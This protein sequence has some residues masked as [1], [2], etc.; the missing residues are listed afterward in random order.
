MDG[1]RKSWLIKIVLFSLLVSMSC[2][3]TAIPVTV[4]P[5]I[6]PQKATDPANPPVPSRPAETI[7]IYSPEPMQQIS[8]GKLEVS[9][10]SEYFFEA[11]LSLVLCGEGGSGAPHPV[12]HGG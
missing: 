7:T 11:S 5:G 9:G 2:R 4:T 12:R 10:Y 1:L 3:S 8:G 6:L